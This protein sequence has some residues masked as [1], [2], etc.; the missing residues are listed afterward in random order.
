MEEFGKGAVAGEGE[1]HAAVTRH[2]EE[3]AVPDAA[4][5]ERH[6]DD[7]AVG[8]EDVEEDLG[9]GLAYAGADRVVEVLNR[10]EEG[11]N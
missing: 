8:P 6:K 3:A 7:G 10:E 11:K 4:H 9:Y 5:D 1:H 2:G